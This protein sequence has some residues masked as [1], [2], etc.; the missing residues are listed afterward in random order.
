MFMRQKLLRAGL[1]ASA[2]F[3]L[4]AAAQA[5]GLPYI[6]GVTVGYSVGLL[7]G[8]AQEYVYNPN[9]SVLSRLDWKS[10]NVA[11]FNATAQYQV[12]NWLRFG[13]NG[14][15]NLSGDSATMD[16]YDF[17]LAG[18]PPSTPGHTEC[19][20]T[21]GTRL[22][23][24][25]MVDAYV[26]GRILDTG[27]ITVDAL[28]GYKYDHYRWEAIGGTANYATLPPGN[29][30]SYEQNWEAPYIGLG[31]AATFGALSLQG[32]VIG[33]WWAKG[34]D[35]DNHHLRS[36]LF[37]EDFDRSSMIGA[38][39]GLAYRLTSSTSLTVDYNY[40]NWMTAKGSTVITNLQTG[41]SGTI[42]GDA[43]GGN[44][45]S[46]VVSL[47][48]KVDLDPA[49]QDVVSLKDGPIEAPL[50]WTGF[51]AG[52]AGGMDW[53]KADWKTTGL[54]LPPLPPNAST[55]SASLDDSGSRAQ[56]FAGYTLASGSLLWGVEA[57]IGK[58]NTS[59]L[60]IGIP[61][62]SNAASLAGS[63]DAVTVGRGWDGTIRGRIGT[64]V[65]PN[66]QVY[67]TGGVAFGEVNA[68]ASCPV[69]NSAWCVA[70]RYEEASETLVGWTAGLGYELG[71]GDNWFTR[72]EY[73]YT[74]LGT[75][76]HTFFANAPIDSV[77]TKTDVSSHQLTFGVL[78]RF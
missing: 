46:H 17:D 24:A 43:A 18:C 33:S 26:A 62:T 6:Q 57:D 11:M 13:V 45:V 42:P 50:I 20:S 52:V 30:I 63:G 64:L 56:I 21:S 67:A 23:Q 59:N 7:N 9:G 61:G 32:R 75:F 37:T 2:A 19:H 51:H 28:A 55:S 68:S 60:H 25:T 40:Q 48:I 22:R 73:R 77:T 27:S 49:R 14:S 36:L 15:M 35:Q 65:M 74:D 44:N 39:I 31:A 4:P 16:D 29:G 3:S 78:K 8:E 41:M 1:L 69:S 47:G 53:Q 54:F 72:G 70:S 34:D 58:S 38:N 5:Q 10:E 12:L 76:D 66:L 71:F